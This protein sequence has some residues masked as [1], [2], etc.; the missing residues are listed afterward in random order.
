[1]QYFV[2]HGLRVKHTVQKMKK[3]VTYIRAGWAMIVLQ[4][5]LTKV[6]IENCSV[7][8]ITITKYKW[9]LTSENVFARLLH[10]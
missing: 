8:K 4:Y 10:T 1:M 2:H 5:C 9:F 3:V 7:H 6:M